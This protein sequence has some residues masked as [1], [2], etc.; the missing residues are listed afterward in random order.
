MTIMHH[1]CTTYI[2]YYNCYWHS[3][4]IYTPLFIQNIS[5]LKIMTSPVNLISACIII[6]TINKRGLKFWSRQNKMC[7]LT[8]QWSI[9]NI[10]CAVT[11]FDQYNNDQNLWRC[12]QIYQQYLIKL[13]CMGNSIPTVCALASQLTEYWVRNTAIVWGVIIGWESNFLLRWLVFPVDDIHNNC[14]V[15]KQCTCMWL[16]SSKVKW[17]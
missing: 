11:L 6:M 7:S 12:G 4:L 1:C 8:I 14:R 2:C 15:M 5:I 9:C 16:C 10:M 13:H 3:L 17:H